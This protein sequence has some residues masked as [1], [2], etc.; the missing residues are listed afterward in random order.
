MLPFLPLAHAPTP[1]S[2]VIT[3]ATGKTWGSLTH[4]PNKFVLKTNIPTGG[5]CFYDALIAR[6]R[7]IDA[8]TFAAYTPDQL[9]D[10]LSRYLLQNCGRYVTEMQQE[11]S[12]RGVLSYEDSNDVVATALA[13]VYI[14]NCLKVEGKKEGGITPKSFWGGTFETQLAVEVYDIRIVVWQLPENKGPGEGMNE[15]MLQESAIPDKN[16]N[17]DGELKE[18][19]SDLRTV[20]LFMT[21]TQ[22]H[23][24][25]AVA[26]R[27]ANAGPSSS[28]T[29]PHAA[30]PS[31]PLDL[32]LLRA[33]RKAEADRQRQTE[34]Q[35]MNERNEE[36]QKHFYEERGKQT[37]KQRQ[38]ETQR[39][40]EIDE[41]IA[42]ELLA[43]ELQ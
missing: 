14:A 23:W 13:D 20:H 1:T 7:E 22:D 35:Q 42:A 15:A 5:D 30:P 27:V 3:S 9:R 33:A 31:G 18:P 38:E 17:E 28:Y 19:I 25:V 36:M 2:G 39:Q 40:R 10:D 11:L 8:T 26:N 16:L 12:F 24:L 29:N 37:L 34:K 4:A 6:L 21:G 43:A 41:E 32:A